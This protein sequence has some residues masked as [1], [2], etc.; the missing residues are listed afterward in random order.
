MD[1]IETIFPISRTEKFLSEISGSVRQL[2]EEYIDSVVDLE[3]KSGELEKV[4]QEL[5]A[6]ENKNQKLSDQLKGVLESNSKI[7]EEKNKAQAYQQEAKKALEKALGDNQQLIGK[8]KLVIQS[9]RSNKIDK[10]KALSQLRTYQSQHASL[11]VALDETST[12]LDI[13]KQELEEERKK[14][15]CA[16][17]SHEQKQAEL[18]GS[19]SALNVSLEGV[20]QDL[21]SAKNQMAKLGSRYDLVCAAISPVLPKSERYIV[22][23]ELLD[24]SL[25]PFIN[26]VKVVENEAE[27]VLKI[28]ALDDELRLADSLAS[29]SERTIVAVAGGFSSGKSSLIT[30]LFADDSVSLP[31]GIEPVTA[32]P[33]YVFHSESVSISGYP[34]GGGNFNVPE[35][36][37]AQLS[38]QFVEEFGF[39]LRDLVPFMS[40]EVPMDSYRNLSFIDL[41][42]YNPGDRG[43]DTDGDKST[44]DEFITQG[45]ALIWVIGLDAN[46]TLPGDDLEHLWDLSEL[47]IPIYVVLNKAD[48]RPMDTH[49]EVLDQ[50][51][52]ELN[53][54]GI[55]YEGIS[56]YSSEC[57]GEIVYRERSLDDVL[58]EWDQPRDAIKTVVKKLFTVFD[59]YE[60]AIEKDISHRNKKGLLVKALELNLLEVGAFDQSQSFS[61]D[62]DKYMGRS[63][64]QTEA[65]PSEGKDLDQSDLIDEIKDQIQRIREDYNTKQ[66]EKDLEELRTIR[67][68]FEESCVGLIEPDTSKRENELIDRDVYAQEA[69][70][71]KLYVSL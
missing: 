18:E 42:G 4:S 15:I 35:P 44:S 57:G 14:A 50:V 28:R 20:K 22:F 71:Q 33:T 7:L 43:G 36:M 26:R 68:K 32:I 2:R 58:T 48:L 67:S 10:Y 65:S 59:E 9:H 23:R 41:P 17:H 40:L 46:G 38:H 12:V 31:I 62:I 63:E 49:D 21:L 69:N 66:A 13:T 25:L 6:L 60:T 27:Q 24:E 39:N 30:S 61:F 3:S 51:I 37:Y 11:E 29:F 5:N 34:K 54:N 16:L 52:D 1:N 64:V 70:A 53:L 45:H 19:L 55:R 47:D 8:L 56:A